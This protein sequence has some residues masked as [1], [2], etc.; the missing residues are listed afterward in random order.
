VAGLTVKAGANVFGE[1]E[2]EDADVV[3]MSIRRRKKKFQDPRE[4]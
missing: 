2:E 3:L 1:E 4:F